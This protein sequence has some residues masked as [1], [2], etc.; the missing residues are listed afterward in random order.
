MEPGLKEHFKLYE[1]FDIMEE[2]RTE[3]ANELK[4]IRYDYWDEFV[5]TMTEENTC[6]KT[7]LARMYD[8]YE[9]LTE[10]WGDWMDDSFAIKAVLC[11]LPLS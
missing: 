8:I 11:S 3:F 9:L 6:L 1:T 5:S 10:V 2:L 4:E 7:H